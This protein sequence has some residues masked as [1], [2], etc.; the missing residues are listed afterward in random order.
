MIKKSPG[1]RNYQRI[2]L[3]IAS[4]AFLFL[5]YKELGFFAWFGLLP[6][7]FAITGSNLR[8]SILYSFI[9]GAG[10]FAGMT[11]W[12]SEL[13]IKYTW[14]MIVAGL[15]LYLIVFGIA[16]H[17]ILNRVKNPYIRILLIPGAWMLIEFARSQTF[18]AFTIGI[19]GYSQHNFLPLMQLTRF[20]GIY[21]VSFLILFFNMALY[22][23]IKAFLKHKKVGLR[24]IA[25]SIGLV[26][27]ISA[28]GINS[29][30]Q[31][32]DRNIAKADYRQLE[33][34]AVQPKI[35]FGKKFR[36][37]GYEAIPEPYSDK[38]FF[39][40]GTELVI[41]PESVLWGTKDENPE[42]FTW[43][44]EAIGSRDIWMLVGQYDH[45]ASGEVWTNSLILY[46][47]DLN[48]QGRYDEI[49][50]VPFSQY[51]PHRN[52]L[53]FLK[54]LDFSLVDIKPGT[55]SDPVLLKNRDLLGF[56]ICYESTLP[57]IAGKFRRNG[58]EIIIVS[59]DDSSLN[60]SIAPWHHLIFSKT[61]AIE[62]GCYVIHCA[63]TGFS[64]II[65][66]AGNFVRKLDLMEKDI[67]YG[68][69]YLIPEKTF[70]AK[71]GNILLYIYL[72][73]SA[74]IAIVYPLWMRKKK[75]R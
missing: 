38:D 18:L 29:M 27:L 57:Y 34:A 1:I 36:N 19:L 58:A 11:Y 33:I 35:L 49:H 8:L 26:I 41:F 7:L 71:Y 17:F 37:K 68:T 2:L 74:L 3:T 16:A 59:S 66:P 46:D 47:G 14:P 61:R 51:M 13:Y 10:F 24:Y 50:P 22:E 52:I 70:Y 43:A 72:A 42:F 60:E 40:P 20:T 32:L 6:F 5:S 73:L 55:S 21:G 30:N 12:L 54:F 63:N 69:V 53:G 67:M 64:A 4:A 23:T 65:S 45:D 39:K 62:N 75:K 56:S 15:S 9:F 28:Y 25:A 44:K 48:E 31:N